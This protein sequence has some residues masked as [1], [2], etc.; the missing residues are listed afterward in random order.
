MVS[1]ISK[2]H[3]KNPFQEA[4]ICSTKSQ[5][6]PFCGRA[7]VW[8]DLAKFHHVGTILKVLVKFFR[9]CLVFGKIMILL[10]QKCFT[11][12]QVLIAIDGQ[13]RL[14]NLAIWSHC[15]ADRRGSKEKNVFS[16]KCLIFNSCGKPSQVFF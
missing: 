11:I 14:S 4:S 9:V 3:S 6:W 1:F 8:P 15:H 12:G 10:W 7:T 5:M 16:L 2:R 13:I